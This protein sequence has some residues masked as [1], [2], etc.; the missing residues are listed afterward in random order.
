MPRRN[1]TFVVCAE[2]VVKY[3]VNV[4]E[5]R[6]SV[7]M[8]EARYAEVAR[9][10]SGSWVIDQ[11]RCTRCGICVRACP[12]A[13]VALE[14]GRLVLARPEACTYCGFCEELCP[15]GAIALA[16]AIVWGDACGAMP[17]HDPPDSTKL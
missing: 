11:E 4:V 15:V 12:E 1:A 9:E 6:R 13:V 17:D 14:D 8:G 2:G 16:Y 5:I 10:S 3:D 7:T